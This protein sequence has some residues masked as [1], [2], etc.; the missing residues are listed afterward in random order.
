MVSDVTLVSPPGGLDLEHGVVG[1]DASELLVCR[2]RPNTG[3]E[4]PDLEPP[5][6][7]VGPEYARPGIVGDLG[8]PELLRSAA[9]EELSLPSC[10]QVPHPLRVAPRRYQVSLTVQDQ[11]VDRGPPPL[12]TPATL[13]RKYARPVHADPDP[14]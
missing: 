12:S 3:E 8:G 9:D 13:Y 10:P 11:Q 6:A 4:H 1:G 14:G 5:L 7:E 2:L